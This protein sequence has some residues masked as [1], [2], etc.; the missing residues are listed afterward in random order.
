[1]EA[2][3]G[4]HFH[5]VV[6]VVTEQKASI[7]GKASK[8]IL[9]AVTRRGP[10]NETRLA[11]YDHTGWVRTLR[12]PALNQS[13]RVADDRRRKP[14]TRGSAAFLQ[15]PAQNVAKA[16]IGFGVTRVQEAHAVEMVARQSGIIKV[17]R[18]R[19]STENIAGLFAGL[20]VPQ[21]PA[22][23]LLVPLRSA[24]AEAQLLP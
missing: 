3:Q 11:L 2:A 23:P 21:S 24:V 6:V 19:L 4:R 22:T 8:A 17:H 15:L 9:G 20:W 1:M 14:A 5:V 13:A 16:A 18:S 7:C 12:L 10:A